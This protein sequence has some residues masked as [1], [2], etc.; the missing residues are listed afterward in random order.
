L[1]HDDAPRARRTEDGVNIY[2][3]KF[4]WDNPGHLLRHM[5]MLLYHQELQKAF[6]L[7]PDDAAFV[8]H[9]IRMY[10]RVFAFLSP[11]H[12]RHGSASLSL[13]RAATRPFEERER[14]TAGTRV[15]LR[16]TG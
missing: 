5:G 13:S 15:S 8:A 4:T 10:H 1:Q 16:A 11:K 6:K 7:S 9:R 12:A 2:A 14:V 3:S